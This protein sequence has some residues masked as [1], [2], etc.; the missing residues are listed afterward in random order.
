VAEDKHGI[1]Y[2]AGYPEEW[3]DPPSRF[4]GYWDSGFEPYRMLEDGP[5]WDDPDEAIRWG[6]ERAPMVF[7]RIGGQIYSAGEEDP[8]DEPVVRWESR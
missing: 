4:S 6:R 1:V 3:P 8:K 2:I 5:G 7:I